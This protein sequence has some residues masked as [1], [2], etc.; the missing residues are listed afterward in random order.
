MFMLHFV[1]SLYVV[2]DKLW[3]TLQLISVNWLT[4][5]DPGDKTGLAWSWPG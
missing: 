1:L 5:D 2:M 4:C 3:I